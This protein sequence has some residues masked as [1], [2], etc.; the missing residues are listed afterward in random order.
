MSSTVSSFR[1]F[2]SAVVI[3]LLSLRDFCKVVLTGEK[4]SKSALLCYTFAVGY[5]RGLETKE[6]GRKGTKRKDSGRSRLPQ[7]LLLY[8][9]RER[10]RESNRE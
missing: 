4:V 9:E 10:E 5:T 3:S 2:V 6:T 7:R 8:R 1:F